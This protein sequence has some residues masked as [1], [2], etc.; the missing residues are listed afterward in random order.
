MY[1]KIVLGIFVTSTVVQLSYWLVLFV[2]LLRPP[3]QEKNKDSELPDIS[4]LIAARNELHNLKNN[5]SRILNQNYHS[6]QVIVVNDNSTD[7][8]AELLLHTQE[9]NANFTFVNAHYHHGGGNKKAA[10]TQ[11]IHTSKTDV[12]LLTDADCCPASVN[13]AKK[14]ISA[15]TPDKDFVLG[16]GPYNKRPGLLNKLIRFD[17]LMIAIQ[18]GSMAITGQAYMGVGRNLVYR[19][20]LF[21]MTNGFDNHKSLLSG[22]DDLFVQS[23]ATN[24]NVALMFEPEAFVYS[25][26]KDSYSAFLKQKIRHIST[27]TSYKLRHKILLGL[28]AL[29]LLLHYVGGITLLLLKVWMPI[30]VSLLIVRMTVSWIIGSRLAG[31]FHEK[32]LQ[33][34]FPLLEASYLINQMI[35]TT[36]LTTKPTSWK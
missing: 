23:A 34:W 3:F 1:P 4:I 28:F 29:T 25:E 2:R 21:E 5:I 8:S 26:P 15:L 16:Y 30:V 11:G 18:Y 31:K 13:W 27:A 32:D 12:L 14:M 7:A 24:L 35:L 36:T 33:L 22:D 10:L 6:H 17:T 20:S 19:K 9:T